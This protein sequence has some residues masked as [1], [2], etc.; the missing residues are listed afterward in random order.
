MTTDS[1]LELQESGWEELRREARKIEGDLDVKLSSY[2]KLGA[3]FTQGEGVGLGL[4]GCD[5]VGLG[6][7]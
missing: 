1:N 4:V 6:K 7:R 5:S 2:A 3:R